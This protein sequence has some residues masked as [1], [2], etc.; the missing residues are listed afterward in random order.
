MLRT[1]RRSRDVEFALYVLLLTVGALRACLTLET[2]TQE[3]LRLLDVAMHSIQRRMHDDSIYDFE[4]FPSD[5]LHSTY[6][7]CSS[8]LFVYRNLALYQTG[9]Y[10]EVLALLNSNRRQEAAVELDEQQSVLIGQICFKIGLEL[11]YK[12]EFTSAIV[13]LKF[14]HSFGISQ[15]FA[16]DQYHTKCEAIL[17]ALF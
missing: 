15:V 9:K 4:R 12:N 11:F 13:W 6:N 8:F 7:S 14:A 2:M 10:D 17:T 3:S 1:E 16:S 5:H